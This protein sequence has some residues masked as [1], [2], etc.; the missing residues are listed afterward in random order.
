MNKHL[1]LVLLKMC[2]AVGADYSKINFKSDHWYHKHTWTF[3]EEDKFTDWLADYLYR[4]K[5][6][7]NH[8]SAFPYKNKKNCRNI[9]ESF[10]ANYGW[11]NKEK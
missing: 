7:F 6:A 5:E 11:K 10:V 9:A 1:T 3:E 4:N 2:K 8:F